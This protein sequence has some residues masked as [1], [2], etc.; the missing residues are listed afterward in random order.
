M[1]YTLTCCRLFLTIRQHIGRPYVEFMLWIS[2]TCSINIAVGLI[3]NDGS[4]FSL[5]QALRQC[6][7]A[8]KGNKTHKKHASSG[9]A[10]KWRTLFPT[11]LEPAWNRLWKYQLHVHVLVGV[12]DLFVGTPLLHTKLSETETKTQESLLVKSIHL[13]L[14][15]QNEVNF[16]KKVF[17]C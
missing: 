10:S 13:L 3:C 12:V 15:L 11:I 16:F 14:R 4:I 9:K 7:W 5:C 2:I 1:F 6:R 8:K 17:W